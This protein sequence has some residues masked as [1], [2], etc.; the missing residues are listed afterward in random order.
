MIIRV[1]SATSKE[2]SEAF[3][4]RTAGYALITHADSS[5]TLNAL[6]NA[7]RGMK[8][9]K[10]YHIMEGPGYSMAMYNGFGESNSKLEELV[11]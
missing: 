7:L 4:S 2:F 10:A 11:L 1:S 8:I 3:A 9:P 6:L 5:D